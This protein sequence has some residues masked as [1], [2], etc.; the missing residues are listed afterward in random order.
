MSQHQYLAAF[1]RYWYIV[2]ISTI[3]GAI[4][5]WGLSQIAT[6]VYTATSS[7]YFSL[8]FGGTANDLNQGSTYTQNQ[9]LSFAQLVESPLVLDP[10]IDDLNL[11][12]T[13]TD[14]ADSIG[15]STPQNT[16]ILEIAV[17]NQDPAV[18]AK[19]ANAVATS[20]SD[21]VEQ[22]APKSAAGDTTVAVRV[23]Q[24][25]AVPSAPSSPN[26][27][28]NLVAGLVLGLLLGSL[29]IVLRELLDTRVRSAAI[30]T[31]VTGAPLLGT[32]E[33]EKRKAVGPVVLRDSLSTAAENYRQLRSNLEF[34]TVDSDSLGLVVTSSIPGEGKSTIALNLA[35]ALAESGRRVLLVDADL[36]RPMVAGYTGLP[37]AAGLTSVLVGRASAE[38]VIQTWGST[39]LDILTSGPI[40]P[41]PSEL[42]SSRMMAELV[43]ELVGSYDAVVF[44]TAPMVAVADA[45][46]L[47]RL[48]DGAIIVVDK[49]RVHRPQLAQTMDSLE[50]S[51]VNV[52]GVVLNRTAPARDK[53]A[54]YH[55]AG[56]APRSG[57]RRIFT[58]RGAAA[59]P[60]AGILPAVGPHAG[61]GGEPRPA[62]SESE[63]SSSASAE[64]DPA[65]SGS[66]G[67][68]D[69][70]AL[71]L[72]FPE[73]DDSPLDEEFED[74]LGDPA[75]D[76]ED[77]YEPARASAARRDTIPERLSKHDG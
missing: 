57:W 19:I 2:V 42:L 75:L 43:D 69:L 31:S 28:L 10:V 1:R 25:A 4:G 17:A 53:Y 22:I 5:G 15:V 13:A 62:G 67:A 35:L 3:I 54:Y 45:G 44:D 61:G 47:A 12:T 26:T 48:V 49:T 72:E 27:R 18:A 32:V 9:M 40:P 29:I 30:A 20:L 6:P 24:Q 16:V 68:V 76:D 37:G 63:V 51:G 23:I 58:R 7:L 38:D 59:Q 11:S 66:A 21:K 73:A 56:E 60:S 36:R 34:V 65:Q 77:A 55:H 39:G 33:R 14:L 74:D 46:I 8:N 64:A 71:E 52:L 41:N 70:A 50:K